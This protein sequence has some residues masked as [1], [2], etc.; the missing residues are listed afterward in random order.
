MKTENRYAPSGVVGLGWQLLY[1]SISGEISNSL[2]TT[3]DKYYYNSADGSFE[4]E[5]ALDG[6]FYIPEYKPWKIK[7]IISNNAIAGWEITKEDGKIYRYGN[8]DKSASQY[9]LTYSPTNATRFELGYNG[10]VSNVDSSLYSSTAYI[11]YEWDISNIQDV[12]GNQATIIYQPV[13]KSLSYG[14]SSTSLQYTSES[15]PY[16]ILD[17]KGNEIDFLLGTMSS[18]EYYNFPQAYEQN[19]FGTKYLDTIYFRGNNIAFKKLAFGYDTVDVYGFGTTKRFLTNLI[20]MDTA[21]NSIP[22]YNFE[23]YTSSSDTNPGALKSL[24]DPSG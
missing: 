1:G 16:K 20:Y 14:S 6:T 11:P 3:D 22:S 7:R 21:G 23:Y 4:L 10:L 9:S 18:N 19:L 8:Y 5:E 13:L 2:D 12:D 15:Y 24:T 17:N